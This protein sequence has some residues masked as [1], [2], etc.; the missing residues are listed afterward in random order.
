MLKDFF[1][2]TGDGGNF[3]MVFDE[4]ILCIPKEEA[5]R[6]FSKIIKESY[7]DLAKKYGPNDSPYYKG[8]SAERNKRDGQVKE[9]I[10]KI[11]DKMEEIADLSIEEH[12]PFE[13]GLL[14]GYKEAM[15][16]IKEELME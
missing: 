8:V 15:D 7:D 11:M 9:V 2:S 13:E 4:G 14:I 16:I 5:D 12:N 10:R 1:Y 6:S 3:S